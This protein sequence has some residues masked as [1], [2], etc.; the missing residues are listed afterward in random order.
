MHPP[1]KA[2]LQLNLCNY[3]QTTKKIISLYGMLSVTAPTLQTSRQSFW[4]VFTL[5]PFRERLAIHWVR[6]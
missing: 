3:Q 6:Y 4:H 1:K 5:G 2:H